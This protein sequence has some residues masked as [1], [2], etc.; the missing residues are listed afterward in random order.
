M[1]ASSFLNT[2]AVLLQCAETSGPKTRAYSADSWLMWTS[3]LCFTRSTVGRPP[4]KMECAGLLNV[5]SG[6][7]WQAHAALHNKPVT[8]ALSH[9]VLY[10]SSRH[11]VALCS[12]ASK[13]WNVQ[14][15]EMPAAGFFKQSSSLDKGRGLLGDAAPKLRLQSS[16]PRHASFP[17]CPL[18]APPRCLSRSRAAVPL[19]LL[20]PQQSEPVV[21]PS[22]GDQARDASFLSGALPWSP[23]APWQGPTQLNPQ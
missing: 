4:G 9:W 20:G 22:R 1:E 3:C 6:L 23:E 12:L 7:C 16:C 13:E 2:F 8:N 11:S 15:L 19:C 21:C 10:F 18:H 5:T 14:P 17:P